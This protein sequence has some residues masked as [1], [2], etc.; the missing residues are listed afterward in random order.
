MFQELTVTGV[1]FLEM[2]EQFLEPR[3][4]QDGVLH[5]VVFQKA[6]A[7]PHFALCVPAYLNETFPN[8]WIG[9]AALRMWAARSPDLTSFD[10]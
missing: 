7:P 3:L 6:G 1:T 5:C 2:L 10:F 8:R 4:T 9:R